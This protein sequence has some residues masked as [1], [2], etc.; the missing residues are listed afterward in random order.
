MNGAR[1]DS[2]DYALP[3]RVVTNSEIAALHPDWRM[4][5]VAKRTGVLQRHIAGDETALDLA[6]LASKRALERAS[7]P[8]ESVDAVLFCTQTPDHIMPPNATLLQARLGLSN[9]VA[10]L[11]FTLACSGYVYG[12]FMAR[13]LIVSGS[14]RT[15][16]LVTGDT[17][18]RLINPNDRGTYTLFGDGAA[19]TLVVRGEDAIGGFEL[20]TD[21]ARAASFEVPAGGARQPHSTATSAESTDGNGNRRSLEQIHMKGMEVLAFAQ[22]EVPSAVH[23]LLRREGITVADLDLVVFHQASQVALDYLGR[24]LRIP[25]HKLYSN[26]DRVGNTVSASLPIALRDAETEDKLHHGDRVLLVGF[27]VGLSWGACL[28]RW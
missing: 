6:T 15:V 19:A 12:L 16:L 22:R 20:G 11:D 24:A 1:I 9:R 7:M 8:P 21:G 17:Y 2:V 14:A 4:V 18:S 23:L 10:A 28:I 5:D 13:S 26:I 3:E 27:G 25:P